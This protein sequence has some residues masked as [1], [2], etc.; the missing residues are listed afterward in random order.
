MGWGWRVHL[1]RLSF[2]WLGTRPSPDFLVAQG[3][4]GLRGPYLPPDAYAY[5]YEK[6]NNK[7]T[8]TH[9]EGMTSGGPVRPPEAREQKHLL[10][11][12]SSHSSESWCGCTLSSCCWTSSTSPSAAPSCIPHRQ[13][14]I[15]SSYRPTVLCV[16]KKCHNTVSSGCAVIYCLQVP[17]KKYIVCRFDYFSAHLSHCGPSPTSSIYK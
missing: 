15:H 13:C 6:N 4:V 7:K 11:L 16:W 12:W 10:K 17:S 9:S 14:A 8:I 3:K 1:W 2:Q 5:V